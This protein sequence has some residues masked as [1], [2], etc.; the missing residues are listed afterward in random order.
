MKKKDNI[1]TKT[2]HKERLR[3]IKL[4]KLEL[5]LKSNLIKRKKNKLKN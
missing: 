2:L 5:R 1:S 4:K 3:E